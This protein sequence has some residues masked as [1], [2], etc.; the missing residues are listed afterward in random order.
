MKAPDEIH[1]RKKLSE[2]IQRE[3][4]DRHS[5]EISAYL[6][7]NP[8]RF[9]GALIIGVYGGQPSWAPV[10]VHSPSEEQ[11]TD[12]QQYR[13]NSDL[14]I[15]LL[16]GSEK[17]FPI[18]GQHRVA[19]IK[20]ALAAT[21]ELNTDSLCAIFVGHN[22]KTEDGKARTRR[23]FTTVNKRARAVSKA[24]RIALDEDDGFAIVIA[25]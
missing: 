8:Q 1:E 20:R 13:V 11:L 16:S 25:D 21:K 3:A 17:L 15:L 18:D 22:P 2:W 14:G 19:G 6:Q 10:T 5:E 23:L 9:L 12:E 7:S 24:A 4:I